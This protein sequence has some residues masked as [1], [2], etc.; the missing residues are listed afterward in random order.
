MSTKNKKNNQ[1]QEAK[2]YFTKADLIKQ[3]A[4]EG[5]ATITETE[6]FYNIFEKVLIEVITNYLEVIL[7]AGLG[8]FVLKTQ[9]AVQLTN[10]TRKK[11]FYPE[12]TIIKFKI[13]DALKKVV[14]KIKLT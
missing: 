10:F 14:K 9:P 6:D 1:K 5:G 13:S 8:R 11:F 7:S 12:S 3:I 4:K 2:F